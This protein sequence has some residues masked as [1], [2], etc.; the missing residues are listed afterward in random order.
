MQYAMKN[1]H[2][3]I[4]FAIL[5]FCLNR[6]KCL[7]AKTCFPK[8]QSHQMRPK[9]HEKPWCPKLGICCPNLGRPLPNFGQALKSLWEGGCERQLNQ[10][11]LI[12]KPYMT[13]IRLRKNYYFN[14]KTR[15]V[16]GKC[17]GKSSEVRVFYGIYK[18]LVFRLKM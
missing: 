17:F 9:I 6:T 13:S 15:K 5:T 12:L 8:P 7:E 2:L 1:R 14:F 18:I 11:Q 3:Q 16:M 4:N 10:L